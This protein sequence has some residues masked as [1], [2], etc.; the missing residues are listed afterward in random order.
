MVA[1]LTLSETSPKLFGAH[2]STNSS[3]AMNGKPT[4]NSSIHFS[5]HMTMEIPFFQRKPDKPP[6]SCRTRAFSTSTSVLAI[7]PPLLNVQSA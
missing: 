2:K 5:M 3:T 6:F 7:Y 1:V 4:S